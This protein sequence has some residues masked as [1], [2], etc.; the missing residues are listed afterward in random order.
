[1]DSDYII[2]VD[3][4]GDHGLETIDPQYP[5]F[6]LSFC[7]FQKE[8]YRNVVVPAFIRFKF[9]TFGHDMVILR[10]YD[11]R[12]E[13]GPFAFLFD[14]ATRRRFHEELGRTIA[15]VPF[16]LVA[17]IIDK[18]R[19]RAQYVFPDNPYEIALTFC[20]ERAYAYLRDEG[21]HE[22]RTMIIV[23]Q[24]GKA[25][26]NALELAFR[27]I[28][29]GG[30]RWGPLPFDIVFADKRTNSTGLQIADLVSHP[31][32]RRHLKPDQP[33]RAYDIIEEKFR[34][35]P[36]GRIGGWGSKVFP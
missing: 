28:A 6:V 29:Q 30:N 21:Q 13:R 19:L 36:D 31:I 32:G 18:T 16:T 25:E 8:D 17:S 5:I 7:I 3:E 23:E 1:M 4:S 26:D 22:R 9:D 15:A 24:R 2:Y 27:R 12:K 34:R 35:R 14:P 11:I 20:M 33:N 10:G